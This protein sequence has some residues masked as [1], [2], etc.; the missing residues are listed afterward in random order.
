[1][2]LRAKETRASLNLQETIDCPVK[3]GDDDIVDNS[4]DM[5]ADIERSR[6]YINPARHHV[7]AFGVGWKSGNDGIDTIERWH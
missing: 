5:R 7:R 2:R 4:P 1:M 3:S 6:R